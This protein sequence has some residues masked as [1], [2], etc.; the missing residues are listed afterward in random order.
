MIVEK[1]FIIYER[2]SMIVEKESLIVERKSLIVE[3]ESMIVERKSKGIG[4]EINFIYPTAILKYQ[5]RKN[6]YRTKACKTSLLL[7]T[8]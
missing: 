3:K 2:K 8:R 5:K 1:E 7:A 6:L 4:K